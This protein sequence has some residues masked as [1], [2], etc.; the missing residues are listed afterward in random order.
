M[1]AV[2]QRVR[3]ASVLLESGQKREIGFGL[4][5]LLAIQKGDDEAKLRRLIQK[6][7][8]I[9]IF[10]GEE[11]KKKRSLLEVKGE[12]LIISQ[13]TLLGDFQK[14]TRASYEKAEKPEAA[15]VLYLK[16]LELS[17]SLGVPTQSGEFQTMMEV[18]VVNIGP[19]TYC[20]EV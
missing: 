7:I 18:E 8:S 17:Q 12:H 13:F 16:S 1:K 14:G 3:R 19:M 11:E 10:D 4:L 6:I 2:I 20:L 9:R 5:T 15:K